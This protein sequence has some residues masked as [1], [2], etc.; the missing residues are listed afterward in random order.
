MIT[1][2]P[3]DADGNAVTELY[4]WDTGITIYLESD[5]ITEDMEV[6]FANRKTGTAHTADGTYISGQLVVEIPDEVLESGKEIY[7]YVYDDGRTILTFTIDVVRR[8]EPEI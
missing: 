6:H 8:A 1:I 4:Q 2:T 7:G 3:Y 5:Y